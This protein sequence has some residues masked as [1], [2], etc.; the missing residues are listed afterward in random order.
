MRTAMPFVVLLLLLLVEK[1]D[2]GSAVIW[3][4]CVFLEFNGK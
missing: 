2:M 4:L 1:G 3:G